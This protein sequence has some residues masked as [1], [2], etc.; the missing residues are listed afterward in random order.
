MARQIIH[1]TDTL[2][3]SRPKV[4]EN[5]AELYDRRF[6]RWSYADAAARDAATYTSEDVGFVA[7]VASP[8]G[9]WR[10]AGVGPLVWEQIGAPRFAP[11]ETIT[12][13]SHTLTPAQAGAWLRMAANGTKTLT[14]ETS[15]DLLDGEWYVRNAA[16]SGDITITAGSGVTITQPESLGLTIPPR[17]SRA[18]K[19]VAAH[20]YEVA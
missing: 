20:E 15:T 5:F 17:G 9:F 1:P 8:L 16:S 10:L 2:R 14:I 7:R 4:N 6:V 3:A 11:V 13:A 12:G 18:I 19:R